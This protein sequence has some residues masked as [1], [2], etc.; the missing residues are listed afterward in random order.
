MNQQ[1]LTEEL[2]VRVE[3]LAEDILGYP[4][5][6][7]SC[8]NTFSYVLNTAEIQTWLNDTEVGRQLRDK[9]IKNNGSLEALG[10]QLK[11]IAQIAKQLVS[12]S[13][14]INSGV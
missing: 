14:R 1:I 8:I 5:K 7:E 12:E 2:C 11:T 4:S 6:F 3:Q 13:R 10:E 9:V